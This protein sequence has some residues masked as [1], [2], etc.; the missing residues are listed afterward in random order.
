MWGTGRPSYC[1]TLRDQHGRYSGEVK[2]ATQNQKGSTLRLKW[3][4]AISPTKASARQPGSRTWNTW[5]TKDPSRMS[6]S[7]KE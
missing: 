2:L 6:V 5:T 1:P 3:E 7:F 4:A